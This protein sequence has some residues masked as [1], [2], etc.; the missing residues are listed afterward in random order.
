MKRRDVLLA[1]GTAALAG[2]TAGCSGILDDDEEERQAY[3]EA[4]ETLV[5]NHEHLEELAEDDDDRD[6]SDIDEL[7]GRLADAE[8]SLEEAADADLDEERAAAEDVVE[9]QELLVDSHE[10]GLEVERAVDD[11]EAVFETDQFDEAATEYDA[12]GELLEDAR[13]L[14]DD[15]EEAHGDLETEVLE[16]REL[17]YDD[18]LGEY[19]GADSV[20]ELE[21]FEE[22]I[23]AMVEMSRGFEALLV[24]LQDIESDRWEVAEREL[25]TALNHF[26]TA[27]ATLS[28]IRDDDDLPGD[29]RPDVIELVSVV[30]DMAD[31]TALTVEAAVAGQRGDYSDADALLAEAGSIF[32]GTA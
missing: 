17:A 6:E 15:L 12:A 27:E 16:E 21:V 22:F 9:F 28:A 32:E 14:F 3:E 10:L 20:D 31:G 13:E 23:D 4:V 25:R 5:A 1:T 19:A 29:V 11:A 2:A 26:E 30:G 18:E 24:G 8:E 7:R